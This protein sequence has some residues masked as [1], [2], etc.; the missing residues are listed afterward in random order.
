[1]RL[2]NLRFRLSSTSVLA[3]LLLAFAVA[4][5]TAVPT[6]TVDA[7]A[8]APQTSTH[9]VL[10]QAAEPARAAATLTGAARKANEDRIDALLSQLDDATLANEARLLPPGDPLYNYVGRALLRRGLPLPR[11][12]DRVAWQFDAGTRPPADA[13][14]YR[15]PLRLAVLLPLSGQLSAAAEPVR[16]GFLPGY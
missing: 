6:R 10:V 16:D 4:G 7:A 2:P 9:P 8:P 13:D 14:G 3:G 12:F 1:M 15:P 11:P 5:C